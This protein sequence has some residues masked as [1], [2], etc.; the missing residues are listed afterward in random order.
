[1]F[2]L[3]ALTPRITGWNDA[4]Y[5]QEFSP[6]LTNK[7]LEEEYAEYEAAR[8]AKDELEQLDGLADLYFV[9]IGGL[10]KLGA[11]PATIDQAIIKG[12]E[13]DM[14]L[15]VSLGALVATPH[16]VLALTAGWAVRRSALLGLS[17]GQF[18]RA[19]KAVCDSNDTKIVVKTQSDV[20]ANLNKGDNYVP[21]TKALQAIL[22]EACH[23]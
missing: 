13:T 21:P 15:D 9:C 3:L 8:K 12:I 7:L 1:M 22:A 10:W 18:A 11:G 16:A 17:P 6:Q 19:V 5:A 2:T 20:K 14:V 4:R 23:A